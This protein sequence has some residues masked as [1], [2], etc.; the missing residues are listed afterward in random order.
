MLAIVVILRVLLTWKVATLSKAQSLNTNTRPKAAAVAEPDAQ[1]DR[2]AA[3]VAGYDHMFKATEG[4][5]ALFMVPDLAATVPTML[6][7]LAD[8][9]AHA[10]TAA[11][12][13]GHDIPERTYVDMFAGVRP[14]GTTAPVLVSALKDMKTSCVALHEAIKAAALQVKA[15]LPSAQVP[16]Q[17]VAAML[18]FTH[19]SLRTVGAYHAWVRSPVSESA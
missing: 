6:P 11:L 3:L 5:M 19:A 18:T 17:L 4:A 16:T 12:V 7:Q 2:V 15:M 14:E 8:I 13:F 9:A 10:A 1:D